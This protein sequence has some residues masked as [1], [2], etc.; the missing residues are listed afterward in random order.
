MTEADSILKQKADIIQHVRRATTFSAGWHEN[1]R[2]WRR[3]YNFDHY[4]TKPLPGEKRY[5]D[6]V[7]T[8]IVDLAVGIMQS[9]EW[10]WR[11]RGLRPT[12]EEEQGT[13]T[14]EKAIAGF[15]D[16]N[17]D[18]YQYDH[19]YE[20]NLNFVRDGG[21]CLLGVWD[22]AIHNSCY[23]IKDISDKDGNLIS[24]AKVYY[25]LPLRIE[26]VDPLQ[27]FL[28]PGGPKRWLCA[29]RK[30]EMSVYDAEETYQ[31]ALKSFTGKSQ[32]EKIDTNGDFLDYWELAYELVPEGA[33]DY[34]GLQSEDD[35]EK[36]KMRKHLVVRN[37]IMF[38]DDFIYP[39]RMMDGYDDLAYTASFYNP[40]SRSNSK[41]WHSILSPLENP[42]KELEDTTNM[43]KHLMLMYSGLPLVARTKHGKAITV[44]KSLGKVINLA[45]GEE[46]GFPEWRGTPPDMDKHL[47]F[48][49]S[50]IQQSGFSDVMYG[51]G[52]EA[53]S[54][55]S[56]SLM[57]DQNRIR[58]EPA[59]AHLENLWSWSARKWV[60]L[61]N[62][63]IPNDYM[64]LYGH[65]RGMDFADTI[66]GGDLEKYTIRCEIKPEFPNEK[67]RNHAM[68]TQAAG[69]L[70]ARILMEE[71]YDIQQP[72]DARL[73]KIQ[74]M[75]EDNPVTLQY[76]IMTELARRAQTGDKI[77]AQVLSQLE[78][79]LQGQQQ[80]QQE[81]SNP[82]Q[83]LGT[84]SSTGQPPLE[85]SP[86]NAAVGNVAAQ[87]N[88]SPNLM[89]GIGV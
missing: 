74:E 9:N 84:Q 63:F 67:V 23:E 72:D 42:V 61:A 17:S 53:S 69:V 43:R 13:S 47:D 78:Q 60:K 44:D 85:Q 30:E 25:D 16:I 20:T 18:R 54:G 68:A 73:M 33:T 6:P 29:I 2:K 41:E 62:N 71:Y 76:T 86:E 38:G 59:I 19:K 50:R 24:N 31:V 49:R 8:N 80:P 79:S 48:A 89:G 83:P 4:D 3:L 34:E 52:I 55:Y 10:V 57:T 70:P 39:I 46:L 77:A 32:Q 82:E 22:D 51:S 87:A 21:A 65:I 14:I 35:V 81:Q 26:V 36:Y 15:I 58:L 66:K 88:A 27:M 45:E 37:A 64:E 5:V 11:S 75:I 56:V 40:A 12:S 1:I 28:L 7:Y